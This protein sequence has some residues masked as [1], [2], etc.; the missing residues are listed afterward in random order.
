[1]PTDGN[2]QAY[3]FLDRLSTEQLLNLLRADF[4]SPEEGNDGL[5]FRIL[6]VI[7][8]REKRNPTGLLSDVDQAW[9]DF[10][11][12]FNTPDG[13]GRSL[14]PT[15]D[16]EIGDTPD[17]PAGHGRPLKRM[18]A[19]A[20]VVAVAV[21]G[22]IAAQALGVD[23]FGALAR[24]TDETFHFTS[25]SAADLGG[26]DSEVLR[27]AVQEA[28]DSCGITIPAPAWYP[29]GTELVQDIEVVEIKDDHMILCDF[30]Y[31]DSFYN[32][33]VQQQSVTDNTLANSF[34]KGPSEVE[35]YSANGRLFYI[36]SNLD[37]RR[38]IYSNFQ[39]TLTIAGDLS[40][41]N[42][43]HIINSIGG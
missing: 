26:T 14:Y 23:V 20:A 1:M 41:E 6:E 5:I 37:G 27:L 18:L 38:A 13:E 36:M 8:E 10:Q 29:E 39:T 42:L 17:K 11:R 40:S 22:M 15:R 34:E 35:E 21:F 2:T 24:W 9:E 3:E 19:L 43:K 16:S 4:D 30:S 7:E 28:F 31:G 32:I 33:T 25:A 12:Y